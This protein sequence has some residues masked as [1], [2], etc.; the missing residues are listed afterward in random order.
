MKNFL[1]TLV[2]VVAILLAGGGVWYFVDSQNTGFSIIIDSPR[3]NEILKID[4]DSVVTW[5]VY[6]FRKI[7]P[8]WVKDVSI[9][10]SLVRADQTLDEIRKSNDTNFIGE[11]LVLTERGSQKFTVPENLSPGEYKIRMQLYGTS[12]STGNPLWGLEYY[13]NGQF[14]IEK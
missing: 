11:D 8:E 2:A 3:T 6:N 14:T 5:H 13:T 7:N 12:N 1:I 10:L 4:D 9:R